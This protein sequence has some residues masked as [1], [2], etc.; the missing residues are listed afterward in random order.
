MRQFMLCTPCGSRSVDALGI[1]MRVVDG[2]LERF[3]VFTFLTLSPHMA[4]VPSLSEIPA[5]SIIKEPQI[6]GDSHPA[7]SPHVE[8]LV[9]EVL[10]WQRAQM[11]IKAWQRAQIPKKYS[12]NVAE[13]NLANRFAKLL[14]RRWKALGREPSRSQLSPSEVALVN[15]VPGVPLHRRSEWLWSIRS[16]VTASPHVETLVKEVLAWQRA[17]IPKKAW[18]RAQIPNRY[19]RNA[20][21]RKLANRF[22]KVLLR[23]G[24]ALGRESS[25]SQL[26]PCEVALVNSVPGV[27][28]HGC[29]A[30]ASCGNRGVQI[31][32]GRSKVR[33]RLATGSSSSS[34]GSRSGRKKAE[35][36][37]SI[38]RTKKE[39]VRVMLAVRR[40]GRP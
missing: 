28:L 26:S 36:K 10:V 30:T 3:R 31:E 40:K 16:S 13:R 20:E 19:S 6:S 37:G 32:A 38:A 1:V 17:Q 5:T 25:L 24:K 27:P 15:S 21:E 11:S 14:Y 22:A 12:R 33:K 35:N 8:T 4:A 18:Q 29:S 23:R 9:N 39:H 34:R 7:D 2:Q